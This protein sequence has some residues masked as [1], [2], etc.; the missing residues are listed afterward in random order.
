M[1]YRLIM[2][3]HF[4]KFDLPRKRLSRSYQ[5]CVNA[6]PAAVVLVLYSVSDRTLSFTWRFYQFYIYD[7]TL[8]HQVLISACYLIRSVKTPFVD[9]C[10]FIFASTST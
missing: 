3:A 4:H 8:L 10:Q 1:I 7:C 2:Y 5:W 6:L 9:S